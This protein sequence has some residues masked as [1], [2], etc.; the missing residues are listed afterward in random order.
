MRKT[1]V[2]KEVRTPR[3]RTMTM[4]RMM[5][6]RRKVKRNGKKVKKSSKMQM[7]EK[8]ATQHLM[9]STIARAIFS[10]Q[11]MNRTR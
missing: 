10:S 8:R 11:T 5:R 1:R 6:M 4:K 3:A 9:S 2:S 7:K